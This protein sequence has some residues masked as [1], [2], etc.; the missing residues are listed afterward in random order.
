MEK[1]LRLIEFSNE[2]LTLQP[3]DA[4]AIEGYELPVNNEVTGEQ[5]PNCCLFHS[6]VFKESEDWFNKEQEKLITNRW[7]QRANYNG[8]ALKVVRQL[9][10]TEYLISEKI[11]NADWYK[12]ITHYIQY[13][14]SSFGIPSVGEHL[15]L[16]ALRYFLLNT[17]NGNWSNEQ[18]ESLVKFVEDYHKPKNEDK[19]DLNLLIDTYQKWLKAFPFELKSYFGDF[20]EYFNNLLPLFI[21]EPERNIYFDCATVIPHTQSSLIKQLTEITKLLISKIDTETLLEQGVISDFNKHTLKLRLEKLRVE[22]SEITQ[23]FNKGEKQY[24]KALKQWLR[25]QI[26][27][28]KDLPPLLQSTQPQPEPKAEPKTIQ[29]KPVFTF[30]GMFVNP[31]DAEPC[32]EILR[33]LEPPTLDAEFN[34]IG[35]AKGIIPLWIRV[36]QNHKPKALIKHFSDKQYAEIL[37]QKIKGLSLTMDASEF[38]KDYTRLTKNNIELQLKTLLSQFSQSGKLGK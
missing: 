18:K 21:G 28:F 14:V 16:S 17:P 36:L 26:E 5:F 29:P 32:L 6:Q 38:R 31:N 19:T 4:Q 20:K 25:V 8:L 30:E 15:Y 3:F 34:Y 22:T 1:S 7:F 11:M 2:E 33:L 37:N 27:F 12:A 13:N 9:S 35:K 24:I 10:Q 23:T